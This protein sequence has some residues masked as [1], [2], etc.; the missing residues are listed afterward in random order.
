MTIASRQP[1]YYSD[2][3]NT[4][5]NNIYSLVKNRD[6][7]D[8]AVPAELKTGFHSEYYGDTNRTNVDSPSQYKISFSRASGCTLSYDLLDTNFS[9]VTTATIAN[10]FEQ[11]L[12]SR[13]INTKSRKE[14]TIKGILNF[15]NNVS[16]FCSVKLVMVTS[17]LTDRQFI[18]YY[19]GA[20]TYPA[21]SPAEDYG[22]ALPTNADIISLVDNLNTTLNAVTKTYTAK[23][24]ISTVSCC[25]SSSS[26]SSSSSAYIAYFNLD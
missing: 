13:G 2:L 15:F 8:P 1:I 3:R 24:S 17:Q 20:V 23:Y 12:I 5:L 7:F 11:F 9:V 26:S 4:V 18:F 22:A 21:V 16:A 25:S 19:P 6:Q 10:E 14:I